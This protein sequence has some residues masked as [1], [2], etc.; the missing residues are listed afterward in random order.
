MSYDIWLTI[1]TGGESPVEISD[2][3]W[4]YTSNV[5]AMWRAAGVDLAEHDGKL[6]GDVAQELALAIV[7]LQEH[8]AKYRAMDSPNGWGTYDN[9]VPALIRLL[10]TYTLHPRA[11]VVVSR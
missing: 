2:T 9:L 6:A 11:T 5:S 8:P 1:D 4:N 3:W 10:D 7:E